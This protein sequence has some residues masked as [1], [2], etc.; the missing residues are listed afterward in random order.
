MDRSAANIT[1][2]NEANY[3]TW[4]I[5]MKMFLMRDDLLRI[6]EGTEVV[7][8]QGTNDATVHAAAVSKFRTRHDR[9]LSNIVLCVEPKLLHILGNPTDAAE[10]WRKLQDV[11]QKKSWANKFRLKKDLYNMKLTSNT[12]MQEHLKK[13]WRYSLSCLLLVTPLRKKIG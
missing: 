13:L 7:P 1:P 10:V 2:L 4:K 12:S 5:Q 11:F 9:A 3:A 6:V 8:V